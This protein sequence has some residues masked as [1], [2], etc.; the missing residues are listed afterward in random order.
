[1]A[2]RKTV[3]V[4]LT[5]KQVEAL[6]WIINIGEDDQKHLLYNG[7]MASDYGAEWPEVATTKAQDFRYL[8]S[9]CAKLGGK[10]QAASCNQTA[11]ELDEASGCKEAKGGAC[12][13]CGTRCDE[14]GI[15]PTC[16]EDEDPDEI[17]CSDCEC[18][19]QR[20]DPYFATP[21]GTYCNSCMGEHVLACGVC[22]DEFDEF[23][24]RECQRCENQF[25]A[26]E[27]D[28]DAEENLCAAC[29][30]L[31]GDDDH[32]AEVTNA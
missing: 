17:E 29:Q 7:Y 18:M 4:T 5:E 1:M 31:V 21:C 19:V 25:N 14:N 11:D 9:V 27:M 32:E 3:T 30:D 28:E 22:A 12:V 2:K 6:L 24:V 8:A 10:H 23:D 15:C 13:T 26:A 20:E 16:D